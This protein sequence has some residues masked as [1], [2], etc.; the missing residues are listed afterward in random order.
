KE[1]HSE[2]I[3]ISHDGMGQSYSKAGIINEFDEIKQLT[4]REKLI[5]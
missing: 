5:I 1:D 4:H 2:A 3:G